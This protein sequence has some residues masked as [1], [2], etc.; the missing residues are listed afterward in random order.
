MVSALGVV[1]G[2]SQ[3]PAS[4]AATRISVEGF[5]RI[6]SAEIELAPLTILLGKNN[7]GKS[8][9]ATLLWGLR[10][11]VWY[12]GGDD[13]V[14]A[15]KK[16]RDF[17]NAKDQSGPH[18]VEAS[19]CARV[20]NNWL[21]RIKLK[22][23]RSLFSCD[24]VSI[25]KLRLSI[26]GHVFVR[27]RARAPAWASDLNFF[28]PASFWSISYDSKVVAEEQSSMI[29][30]RHGNL[31]DQ[32]FTKVVERLSLG[33]HGAPGDHPVYIPAAR[34]GLVLAI[35]D[36]IKGALSTFSR[37][38]GDARSARTLTLPMIQFLRSFIDRGS[39]AS[40]K[41]API[42]EFLSNSVLE[43]Q[44]HI[45]HEEVPTFEY[46]P[47]HSDQRLPM[48]VVSSMVTEL[49]PIIATIRQSNLLGGLIIEEPEAHLHLSAQRAMARTIAK[50]VNDG[51]PVVVTTHSDTFVQQLNILMQLH[52]KSSAFVSELGYDE[53]DLIDMKQV[54]AYE[55]V[56]GP[57]G[58]VACRCE[59]TDHGIVAPSLNQTIIQ[60]ADELMRA[61]AE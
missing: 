50:L 48:H 51:V 13:L 15:P 44:I 53:S 37:H 36:L 58:S 54:R 17:I 39:R 29:T 8:Y 3:T 11:N 52:G 33:A 32:L 12:A 4:K 59:M 46:Q 49:A 25:D 22:F 23:V 45:E 28:K 2:A 24:S 30:G 42:A 55:L 9:L 6:A 5:G 60:L 27:R 40:S 35:N 19:E 14:H 47:K 61:S 18:V 26:D 38:S 43:G 41:H 34:T 1:Y 20:L 31:P 57:K 16:F 7:S 56:A 21:D 10:S